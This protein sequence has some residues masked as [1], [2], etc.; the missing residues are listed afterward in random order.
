MRNLVHGNLVQVGEFLLE[1]EVLDVV[2]LVDGV[3]EGERSHVV[4]AGAALPADLDDHEGA[5][6]LLGDV[7][8]LQHLVDKEVVHLLVDGLLAGFGKR[9]VGEVVVEVILHVEPLALTLAAVVVV[10]HVL[11]H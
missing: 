7:F 6:V 10:L 1:F 8:H 9:D 2:H 3:L 11:E 4:E 5:L